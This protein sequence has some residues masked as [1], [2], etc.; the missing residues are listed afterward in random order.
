MLNNWFQ[1]LVFESLEQLGASK[2]AK[3]WKWFVYLI[4]IQLWKYMYISN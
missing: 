3:K 1:F 2:D 4:R